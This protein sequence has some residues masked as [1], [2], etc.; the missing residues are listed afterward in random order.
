[1]LVVASEDQ[2]FTSDHKSEAITQIAF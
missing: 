2:V 1:L